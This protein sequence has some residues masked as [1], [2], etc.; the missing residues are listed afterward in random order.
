MYHH[1]HPRRHRRSIRLTGYDYAQAGAYFITICTQDRE[2]LFGEVVDGEMHMNAAGKIVYEEWLRTEA[3]RSEVKLDVFQVM[4][5]HIHGIVFITGDRV[6]HVGA[7]GR[8]PLRRAPKSLGSLVA[9]FKSTV[10][11]R[12]NQMRCTPGQP[13]W[14]RNYYEH[15]IRNE[16]ELDAVRQYIVD[17]PARWPEDRENPKNFLEL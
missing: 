2:C 12:I 7:H 4:P 5:N 13:V 16:R 9:G 1:Q 17:N 11:K 6:D 14:Q 3:I 10:T 15:V 8:A